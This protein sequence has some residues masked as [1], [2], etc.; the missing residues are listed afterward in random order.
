[1]AHAQPDDVVARYG[2]DEFA[3]I[4]PEAR[5]LDLG[6]FSKELEAAVGQTVTLLDREVTISAS[7]G[8]AVAAAGEDVHEVVHFADLAM[9]MKKT[10][11]SRSRAAR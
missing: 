9:Y 8:A 11:R 7:V 1:M 10:R 3:L 4:R 6:S 5:P 2:G